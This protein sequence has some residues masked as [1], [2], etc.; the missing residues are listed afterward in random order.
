MKVFKFS[1]IILPILLI[2][3]ITAYLIGFQELLHPKE[4]YDNNPDVTDNHVL[5]KGL[6]IYYLEQGGKELPTVIF[7]H[8]WAGI[9]D[10]TSIR[11]ILTIFHKNGY[12]AI[13]IE[14]PGMGRSSTP[15]ITWTNELYADFLNDFT[16]SLQMKNIILVGQS[17]VM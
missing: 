12:R 8:G 17:F 7:L 16:D 6:N 9:Y 4:P 1:V 10:Q 2:F 5:I 14:L 15:S 13:A 3:L 11:Q